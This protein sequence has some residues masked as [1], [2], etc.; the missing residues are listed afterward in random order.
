MRIL[1]LQNESILLEHLAMGDESAF[2]KIFVHYWDTIY[3]TALRFMKSADLA[4]DITQDVF[5]Q[6]WTKRNVLPTV[7]KFSGY[8]FMVTRNMVFD[9]M[10]KNMLNGKMD[11]Y[12][13]L[14]FRE[15]DTSS[16]MRAE[17]KDLGA[18]IEG[19]ISRMPAKQQ[20]AFRMSRFDGKSHEEIAQVMNISRLS[21]KNYIVKSLL[22]LRQL[23]GD[24]FGELLQLLLLLLWVWR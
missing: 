7:K 5:A 4:E 20:V 22:M 18:Q 16:Y 21:V 1:P 14:Y 8:V 9:Q 24:S 17:M 13:K 2:E 10:R 23:L 11:D 3:S 12:L 6:L 19:A 15:D